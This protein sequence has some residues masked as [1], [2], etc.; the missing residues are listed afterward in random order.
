LGSISK[1][2]IVLEVVFET[3]AKLAF[4]S[5]GG[6]VVVVIVMEL[7]EH[8]TNSTANISTD[9]RLAGFADEKVR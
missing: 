4:C 5:M 6:G 3:K 9:A 1:A 7:P 8:P 2:E